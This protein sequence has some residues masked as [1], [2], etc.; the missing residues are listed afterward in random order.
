[1]NKWII[2]GSGAGGLVATSE[3][4]K[5]D[6]AGITLLESGGPPSGH[7]NLSFENLKARGLHIALG[8][9][10]LKIGEAHCLGGGPAINSRI[11]HSCKDSIDGD[12]D[13]V[14]DIGKIH[15]K[16]LTPLEKSLSYSTSPFTFSRSRFFG[17]IS[18]TLLNSALNSGI[19]LQTHETVLRIEKNGQNWKVITQKNERQREYLTERVVFA[20]GPFSTTRLLRG[21]ATPFHTKIFFHPQFRVLAHFPDFVKE[22]SGIL[23]LQFYD[24]VANYGFSV[25][26]PRDLLAFASSTPQHFPRILESR[27]NIYAFYAAPRLPFAIHLLNGRWKFV[28]FTQKEKESVA[29]SLIKLSCFLKEHGAK[30]TLLAHKRAQWNK[31]KLKFTELNV[32]TVHLMGGLSSGE[33]KDKLCDAF[34]RVKG[35]SGL[36]V[37]DSSLLNGPLYKNPQGTIMALGKR[38]IAMW[39]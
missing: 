33:S 25:D 3:L 8:R 14:E 9:P 37:A 31:D 7:P 11:Y 16:E 4:A 34:G 19:K 24:D 18:Q 32:T 35:H 15:E 39:I 17:N 38:N 10:I 22:H 12:W 21:I 28:K 2:I 6:G 30:E 29:Q 5:K 1:M 23:G 26:A 20:G 13:W 27:K 36:Y